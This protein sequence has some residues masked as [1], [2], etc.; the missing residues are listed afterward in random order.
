[1]RVDSCEPDLTIYS[2]WWISTSTVNCRL[3]KRHRQRLAS[4]RRPPKYRARRGQNP[5]T[6]TQAWAQTEAR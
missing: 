6:I 2:R 3:K 1:M 4:P 5:F